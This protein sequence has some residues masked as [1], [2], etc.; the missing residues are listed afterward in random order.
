M[1]TA[2]LTAAS[3]VIA[4]IAAFVAGLLA[5]SSTASSPAPGGGPGGD[6]ASSDAPVSVVES[7]SAADATADATDAA[8]APN[9][10]GE[11]L[12]DGPSSSD[13]GD[14]GIDGNYMPPPV[15][16]VCSQTATWG[17][18][19][20]LSISTPDDDE[21]DSITP[22]ELTI[23]WTEGT[24]SSAT[25]EI[26]DRAS[27]TDAFG[28]PQSLPAGQY[29]A[30]RVSLSPD[31]LRL[32]VVNA[33]AHGFSE[34]TR[35]ARTSS[36]AFGAATAGSY[37]TLNGIIPPEAS[38][39]DP[40]LGADDAVFYYS[41]YGGTQTATIYR[42]ARLLSTDPWPA[43]AALPASTGLAAQGS[44][45]PPPHRHLLGRPDAVHLGRDH[46]D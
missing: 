32:V 43:G 12:A 26:A 37:S 33:D 11:G 20:L 29:T 34:L 7:G 45:A 5:C 24:G 23:A 10:H 41:V 44:S 28:A 1:R 27:K 13:A 46:G 35:S 17:A 19:T 14:S 9:G 30:D 31:G 16:T 39:G 22:D 38:Y 42:S 36:S 8:D 25:I 4:S 6:D 40:L 18:G 2:D 15:G 21:L 3:A